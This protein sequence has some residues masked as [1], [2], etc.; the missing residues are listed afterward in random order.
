MIEVKWL[1]KFGSLRI[2]NFIF[3]LKYDVDFLTSIFYLF[4][5]VKVLSNV[6]GIVIGGVFYLFFFY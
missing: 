4:I 1:V 5:F 6:T 2:I 3:F